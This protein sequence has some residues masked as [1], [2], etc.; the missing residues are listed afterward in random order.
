MGL[1]LLVLG[2][3]LLVRGAVRLA[4]G[5]QVRQ[6][7]VGLT[8]VGFGSSAPQLAVSLQAAYTGAPD[9]AVGS[10][11]GSNIFSILMVLGL[12]ALVVPLRVPRQVIR[13]DVP[14]MIAASFLVFGMA[15]NQYLGRLEG[16]LLLGCLL[17][18]LY[19]LRRQAQR[20]GRHWR[21]EPTSTRQ[22]WWPLCVAAMAGGIVLLLLGG[23]LLLDAAVEIAAEYGLSDRFIGLTIVAVGTSMPQLA[24]S[25]IA[26]M[27]GQRDIA[28]GNVIGGNLFNL[29]GVLGLT[30]VI[31]PAPLTVSPNALAFDLPVMV[32]V[33]ALCLPLFYAGYRVTRFEGLLL[34][35][36]YAAYG[37]HVVAFTTGLGIAGRLEHLMQFY[38]LPLL[39]VSM[40]L[41]IVRGLRLSK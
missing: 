14:L 20:H 37:V 17:L 31:A 38:G 8:V 22:R 28:V 39:A 6:L 30:A 15:M 35:A 10:V 40:L 24:T 9:I 27:R 5:W 21:N 4:A 16:L 12:S 41:A 18:Y 26:A 7:I 2:A 32:A 33:A 23:H 29:L 36:L 19:L 34:L 25:L 1:L 3:E 11:F 13:L